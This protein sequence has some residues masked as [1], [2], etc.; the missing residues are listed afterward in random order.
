MNIN[1]IFVQDNWTALLNACQNG[2]LDIVR[3]VIER[4]AE[5]EHYDCVSFK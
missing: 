4:D 5:I 2:N 3:A 1:E